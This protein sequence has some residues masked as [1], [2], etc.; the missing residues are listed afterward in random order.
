[1]K[2]KVFLSVLSVVLVFVVIVNCQV[3]VEPLVSGK[4]AV[5]QLQDCDYQF[6]AMQS[7]ER[8][9]AALPVVL[10]ALSAVFNVWLWW[11]KERK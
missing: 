11:P 7:F 2:I 3:S 4:L 6:I 10:A 5:N 8:H 9:R 1:M